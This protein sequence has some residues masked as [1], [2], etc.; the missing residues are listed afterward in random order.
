MDM[1]HSPS[2]PH[3]KPPP[4]LLYSLQASHAWLGHLVSGYCLITVPGTSLIGGCLP[5]EL[6][7]LRTAPLSANKIQ[8]R[9][10]SIHSHLMAFVK[11]QLRLT[12]H[13]IGCLHIPSPS[14]QFILISPS[15]EDER[16]GK[17]TDWFGQLCDLME[18]WITVLAVIFFHPFHFSFSSLHWFLLSWRDLK[19]QH[20]NEVTR[21]NEPRNPRLRCYTNIMCMIFHM[22]PVS[23]ILWAQVLTQMFQWL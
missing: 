13:L 16:R 20:R 22:W 5:P 9:P 19:A 12:W 18:E 17:V 21:L 15:L 4:F 2:F 11:G 23:N 10:Y 8:W 3:P 1:W 14:D 7:G 6:I